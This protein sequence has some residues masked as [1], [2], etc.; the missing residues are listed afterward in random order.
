MNNTVAKSTKPGIT[1]FTEPELIDWALKNGEKKFRIRQFFQWF[2]QKKVTSLDAMTD[3]SKSFR[4]KLGEHFSFARIPIVTRQTA[5]DGSIKFLQQLEDG[6]HIESVLIRHGDHNT[7]CISTQVGCGMGCKFCL[8][9]TMGLKRNLTAGE[10]VEQVLNGFALLPENEFIRNIVYMGMGEPFHNY[11]NTMKSLEI[12]LNPMGFDFSWRRITISTAGIVEGI[13]RFAAETKV[14]A[15]LAIS[16][17]GVT[18]EERQRLMPI[19]KKNN[20]D[21]LLSACRDYYR[22]TQNRITFEYVMLDDLTDSLASAKKLV[23]LLHGMKSKV[24]LIP[25]NESGNKEFRKSSEK[26]ITEFH[27]YLLDHGIVATL[28]LSKG[29]DISAAC[30]QLATQSNISR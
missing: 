21:S 12:L 7:L 10:I 3:L 25:Y 8:T 6:Y 29:S 20:L 23:R 17:N 30:G 4:Q 14:K 1:D 2:Y 27:Q 16:L 19:T 11:E 13:Q 9:S 15:N 26:R 5:S 28:R 18:Q 22:M 24:N